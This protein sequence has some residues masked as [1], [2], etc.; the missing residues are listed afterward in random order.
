MLIFGTFT[1]MEGEEIKCEVFF[2]R[3][4]MRGEITKN[5]Y[6]SVYTYSKNPCATARCNLVPQFMTGRIHFFLGN[7]FLIL[8]FDSPSLFFSILFII[9]KFAL[10][11][12]LNMNEQKART[13]LINMRRQ[14]I[15]LARG[16]Y[17]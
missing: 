17:R 5:C 7:P 2:L 14:M 9:L 1:L 4:E 15:M 12:V 13:F 6:Y 11:S 10:E 16:C 3:N 8:F